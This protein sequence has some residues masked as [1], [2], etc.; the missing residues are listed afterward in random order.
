MEIIQELSHIETI[1]SSGDGS[2][3]HRNAWLRLQEIMRELSL[4][5]LI[6]ILTVFDNKDIQSF[7]HHRLNTLRN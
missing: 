3:T 2:E 5:Q 7:A 6:N 1:I 4:H